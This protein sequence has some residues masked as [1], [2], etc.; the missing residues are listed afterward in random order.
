MKMKNGHIKETMNKHLHNRPADKI[1]NLGRSLMA[2]IYYFYV[3]AEHIDVN[4]E[5]RPTCREKRSIGGLPSL[6]GGLSSIGSLFGSQPQH[7][8]PPKY[9]VWK[10]HKYSGIH[11]KPVT[12]EELAAA[13]PPAEHIN[14]FGVHEVQ[15]YPPK[16][17]QLPEY[18]PEPYSLDPYP[19][20]DGDT[21]AALAAIDSLGAFG[22][23]LPDVPRGRT[24]RSAEAEDRVGIARLPLKI[25]KKALLALL[26]KGKKGGL[27]G[28]LGGFGGGIGG[29]GGGFSSLTGGFSGIS[30]GLSSGLGLQS[31]VNYFSPQEAEGPYPGHTTV[32]RTP[33]SPGFLSG[34]SLGGGSNTHQGIPVELPEPSLPEIPQLTLVPEAPK[35]PQ[36]T[37]PGNY[38]L[39]YSTG[40]YVTIK[41]P[42][43][44]LAPPPV[45][46]PPQPEYGL[47]AQ[48]YSLPLT[49]YGPPANEY[50]PPAAPLPEYGPPAAPLPE[51]GSPK[52]TF[53]TDSLFQLPHYQAKVIS[54]AVREKYFRERIPSAR[55]NSGKRRPGRGYRARFHERFG[56]QF[57]EYRTHAVRSGSRSKGL[58][59]SAC[60]AIRYLPEQQSSSNNDCQAAISYWPGILSCGY[61][62]PHESQ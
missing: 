15:G 46:G 52:E 23:L 55:R 53:S 36:L 59:K 57:I 10:V 30:S 4:N 18:H 54:E 12:H 48:E 38:K 9:P 14:E 2:S 26:R 42:K 62:F 50:G 49:Q 28:S 3:T 40:S 39:P 32:Y 27:G 47:P 1:E 5:M 58:W 60:L 11:L 31:L 37:L 22:S 20:A 56:A 8:S 34:L 35:L 61:T 13:S 16:V 21:R 24:G 19:A 17:V 6:A 29:I 33:T 51:Y 43:P 45:Y 41:V 7:Q 44:P 25:K